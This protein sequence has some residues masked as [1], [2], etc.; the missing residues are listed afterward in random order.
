M[1]KNNREYRSVELTAAGSDEEKYSVRG[2]A[3]TFDAYTL[4]EMDGIK[5]QERI[6]RNAF[7]GCDMSDVVFRI[8]HR[9]AVYARVSAGTLKVDIDDKGLAFN[10][11]LSKTANS[12]AIA[13]DIAAGNYPQASFAFTV[14][15][16]HYEPEAHTRVIDAVSKLYDVSPVTWPANPGTDV[17][18]DMRGYFES[19]E[20]AV[21]KAKEQRER[22]KKRLLLRLRLD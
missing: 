14:E 12:R 21:K 4:F 17:T 2:H 6:E 11:D 16:E 10:A 15:K 8:D 1:A 22:D 9:G 3:A 5:Y 13:E 7:D 19:Q 18:A 20:S